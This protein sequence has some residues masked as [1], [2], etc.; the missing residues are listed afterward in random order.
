[1]GE[2]CSEESV[3]GLKVF[4]ERGVSRQGRTD[5][6]ERQRL[7]RLEARRFGFMIG[8]LAQ[9]A[10]ELVFMAAELLL[11]L[12]DVLRRVFFLLELFLLD[13]VVVPV[14]LFAQATDALGQRTV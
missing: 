10:Q 13:A 9:D 6:V 2:D 12:L 5:L 8:K 3:A 4:D 14:Q 7:R 11:Q 1:M